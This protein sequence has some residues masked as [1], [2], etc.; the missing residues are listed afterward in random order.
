M[1]LHHRDRVVHL[2][3]APA[4]L[5]VGFARSDRLKIDEVFPPTSIRRL[6]EHREQTEVVSL[7]LDRTDGIAPQYLSVQFGY[8]SPVQ[9]WALVLV[10]ALFFVLGHAM[11][12]VLGRAALRAGDALRARVHVGGW[13]GGPRR[14]ESGVVLDRA[15]VAQLVPGRTTRAEVLRLCGPPTEEHEQLAQPDRRTLVYRGRRVAPAARRV[16]GWITTVAHWQVER[17]E[18]RVQLVRD[19]VDDVAAE[20]RHCRLGTDEAPDRTQ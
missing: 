12:P 16:L 9:A 6:S 13:G 11:G 8:F 5:A 1:Y 20:T 17:H 19:V 14:R 2:S 18:V 4:E 3:E 10:P 7:F 15:A